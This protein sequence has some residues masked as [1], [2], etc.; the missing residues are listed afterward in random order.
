MSDLTYHGR[1]ISELLDGMYAAG[2]SDGCFERFVKKIPSSQFGY[3]DEGLLRK[4]YLAHIGLAD[5]V[6]KPGNVEMY[7]RDKYSETES[8]KFRN[9][10]N[11]TFHQIHP[12]DRTAEK[13]MDLDLNRL[14]LLP[15]LPT[16]RHKSNITLTSAISA[17]QKHN[18][19]K[20]PANYWHGHWLN[21]HQEFIP[22]EWKVKLRSNFGQGKRTRIIF[23][24]VRL[25]NV[26]RTT[27][28]PEGVCYP[29]FEID[30]DGYRIVF[31]LDM[32]PKYGPYKE[33]VCRYDYF[34]CFKE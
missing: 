8:G 29:Y 23:P 18:P 33:L 22:D 27:N 7:A 28:I 19:E 31:K 14:T 16:N 26:P 30:I 24:G 13:N 2:F 11:G 32:Q 21:L 1:L 10:N 12:D 25:L 6:M 17:F 4:L 20:L 34:A 3:P 9:L 15:A 5:F